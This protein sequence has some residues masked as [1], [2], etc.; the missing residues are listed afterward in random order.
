MELLPTLLVTLVGA[1]LF[2]TFI[3]S[4]PR[5]HRAILWAALAAHL[6]FPH[7]LWWVMT[8]YYGGDG[9][10]LWFFWEGER[11]AE[12]LRVDFER[13]LSDLYFLTVRGT[14][15]SFMV[16]L[17]TVCMYVVGDFRVGIVAVSLA[18]CAGQFA[19][20]RGVMPWVAP[21]ERVRVAIGVLLVPSTLFWT[22][23]L[24]KE[25]VAMAGLGFAVLGMSQV[26]S[27]DLRRGLAPIGLGALLV[28]R[29]KAY[30]LAP[31]A[32]SF[33]I[34][35]AWSRADADSRRSILA[36]PGRI[37]LAAAG[38][39][40]L[41]VLLSRWFPQYSMDSFAEEA[42]RL[43][44]LAARGGSRFALGAEGGET[45]L[46]GQLSLA[47]VGALSALF[48]P[49]PFE[50]RNSLMAAS[51]LEMGVLSFLLARAVVGAGAPAIFRRTVDSPLLLSSI[52]FALLFGVAVGLTTTNF[53]T[54]S[55][56]RV[57]MLPFYVSWLL[58]A[59][60][61]VPEAVGR[62]KRRA[63]AAQRRRPGLA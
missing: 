27:G 33:A 63:R 24:V 18:S 62:A 13:G 4:C 60:A 59:G 5:E 16:A 50:V 31:A 7:V 2:G 25:A 28:L 35:Y 21:S 12:I 53:G 37:I 3:Q 42:T 46:A 44:G 47:P 36:R 48:R 17:A 51:A 40:A 56:Y 9:D 29:S 14:S 23:G 22:S 41:I 30:I 45:S 32:V 34:W 26:L 20:Y 10:A 49:F 1:T 39:I 38:A 58:V 43:R 11:I 6:V 52:V 15:T 55:R 61:P 8:V 19:M 54:L 57:P